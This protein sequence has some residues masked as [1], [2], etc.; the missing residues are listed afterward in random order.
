MFDPYARDTPGVSDPAN[1]IFLITPDDGENLERAVKALRIWN[2]AEE[3]ATIS[4][5]TIKDT[6]FTITVPAG[7]LWVEPIRAKAINATGTSVGLVIHGYT[8]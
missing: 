6:A 5:V 8:D 1:D 4:G 3:V 7:S 2:P